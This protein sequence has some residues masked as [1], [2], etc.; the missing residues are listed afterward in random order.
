MSQ[1]ADK[2]HPLQHFLYKGNK[3]KWDCLCQKEFEQVKVYLA[4]P[5]ILVPLV[6]RQ[7]LI[8]YISATSVA[9]GAL[10]A[11]LD[12]NGNEQAIYYLSLLLLREVV[13]L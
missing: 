1:L 3:F 6:A 7:P 4:N 11:Q 2:V 5:P 8:L 10:L 9:L 12:D 13:W